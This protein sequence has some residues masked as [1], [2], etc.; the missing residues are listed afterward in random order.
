M[1][2]VRA[3]GLEHDPLVVD[4]LEP[5]ERN[6]LP[7]V[8]NVGQGVLDAPWEDGPP[9]PSGSC[10]LSPSPRRTTH[11]RAMRSTDSSS[12]RAPSRAAGTH[13]RACDSSLTRLML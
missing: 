2:G 5:L 4:V 8:M 13:A 10:Y 1:L 11:L 7:R 3:F 12:V 9:R 6:L